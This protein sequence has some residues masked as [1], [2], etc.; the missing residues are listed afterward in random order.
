MKDN[1]LVLKKLLNVFVF[2]AIVFLVFWGGAK[3]IVYF[4]PIFIGLL[5]ALIANPLVKFLEKKLKI[6]RK[7]GS[8]ITIVLTLALI[9]FLCYLLIARLVREGANLLQNA[10]E[11]YKSVTMQLEGVMQNS[12]GRMPAGLADILE[13][14]GGALS[15]S[16]GGI[17]SKISEPTV[18]ASVAVAKSIPEFLLYT[19]ITV[20]AAYFLVADRAKIG[21]AFKKCLPDSVSNTIHYIYRSFVD[22]VWGYF[23]AQFQIMGI[24]FVI[25]LIGF[26]VLGVKYAWL[27][28]A[29][30]AFLD[31]LPVFGTGTVIIPWGV[32]CALVGDYRLLIGLVIIYIISQLTHQL[33][34]P[35]LIGDQVGLDPFL[36]LVLIFV[37][38]KI[39]GII[40]MLIALPVAIIIINLYKDG[41]FDG[42]IDDVKYLIDTFNKFRLSGRTVKNPI[43][44]GSVGGTTNSDNTEIKNEEQPKQASKG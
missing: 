40:G 4:M 26:Y 39:N 23:K 13:K 27:I 3:L 31:M 24:I 28:A 32:Y 34:Q 42:I 38:Y 6:K 18:A 20:L 41:F 29:I 37:G 25:L 16:I 9:L 7:I 21:A 2:L 33:L 1:K 12:A 5:I 43:S 17:I 30:T 44:E 35:K 11:I 8:V 14:V 19:I 36:T 15:H 10:P 22:A